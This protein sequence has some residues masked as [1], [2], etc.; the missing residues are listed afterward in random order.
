MYQHR[1]A[2]LPVEELAGVPQPLVVLL[3]ALLEKNPW[4][5]FSNPGEL[6]KAISTITGLIEAGR[7]ITRE[8]L[9]KMP[10]AASRAGTRKPPA[11]LRPKKISIAKLPVTDRCL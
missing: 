10:S 9:H 5:R 4:R 6:L 7:R 2:F 8:G 11:K 3:A 1:R